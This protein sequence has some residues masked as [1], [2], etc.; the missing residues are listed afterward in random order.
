MYSIVSFS[1]S[2]ADIQQD[3]YLLYLHLTSFLRPGT[4]SDIGV[5]RSGGTTAVLIHTNVLS[6]LCCIYYTILVCGLLLPDPAV[7]TED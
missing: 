6:E 5:D 1:R 3:I 4:G 2:G 7:I